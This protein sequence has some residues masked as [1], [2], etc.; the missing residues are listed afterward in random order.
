MDFQNVTSL[1][2]GKEEWEQGDKKV[3]DI[4]ASTAHV[5]M[6]V[7]TH[8]NGAAEQKIG[9]M[10]QGKWDVFS[11]AACPSTKNK[12]FSYGGAMVQTRKFLTTRP[13]AGSTKVGSVWR[14]GPQPSSY[15]TY[16]F[17]KL[18]SVWVATA[19][20]YFKEGLE[21]EIADQIV[22]GLQNVVQAGFPLA[23]MADFNATPEQV[24]ASG[25]LTK[26]GVFIGRT[27]AKTSTAREIDFG[28][29]SH[30][31]QKAY[32]G[33]VQVVRP[34]STHV[35]LRT[36]FKRGEALMQ[37]V[38]KVPK[39]LPDLDANTK[40][41][42]VGKAAWARR[43]QIYGNP[44]KNLEETIPA[45]IF[46][47]RPVH[48][49]D[50]AFPEE[51]RMG[52][53]T[54]SDFDTRALGGTATP[55]QEPV[56]DPAERL[57]RCADEAASKV[58]RWDWSEVVTNKFELPPRACEK[59]VDQ[60]PFVHRLPVQAQAASQCVGQCLSEWVRLWE[61]WTL[62]MAGVPE[63][64]R[65]PYCGRQRAAQW[66]QVPV[67]NT[68]SCPVGQVAPD[69]SMAERAAASLDQL[70]QKALEDRGNFQLRDNL[71]TLLDSEHPTMARLEAVIGFAAFGRLR[72][73][74]LDLLRWMCGDLASEV[75]AGSIARG[76][77][78]DLKGRASAALAKVRQQQAERRPVQKQQD[79]DELFASGARLAHKLTNQPNTAHDPGLA[80]D[81]TTSHESHMG[82]QWAKFQ[83]L[84]QANVP[85][86]AAGYYQA[87]C[88]VREQL[89]RQRA[90]GQSWTLQQLKE[91][92]Q[93]ARLRRALQNFKKRT[94]TGF[95]NVVLAQ[96][97]DLPDCVLEP[98]AETMAYSAHWCVGPSN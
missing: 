67:G 79:M 25:I 50:F 23:L 61:D 30:S 2:Q 45:E 9:R 37:W 11:G 83:K 42:F 38:L 66:M 15:W 21:G 76:P 46:F 70:V 69:L 95:C 49:Q 62:E 44:W 33:M 78:R 14:A 75:P 43:M 89:M 19:T 12:A 60:H 54:P 87:Y 48:L 20:A 93:P 56:P 1:K 55:T 98:L 72:K 57:R 74:L 73:G 29:F 36:A 59:G 77:P 68:R 80:S 27:G 7:E 47:E 86:A 71:Y 5:H 88:E 39:R 65:A 13:P 91:K 26:L 40:G 53:E 85:D 31:L 4:N 90:R 3:Q 52:G 28:L 63:E 18:A 34:F 84:W 92:F 8:A 82:D 97:R 81:G 35:G 16:T 10:F 58:E 17:V 64:K 24:A 32:V 51:L 94:S 96:L 22:H 6:S 41:G